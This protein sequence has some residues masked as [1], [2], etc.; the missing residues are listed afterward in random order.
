MGRL[1]HSGIAEIA[2]IGKNFTADERGSTRIK[3]SGVKA[4]SSLRFGM[5]T[6]KWD[7]LGC[8]R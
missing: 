4:D 1:A 3:K 8:F 5:T 7:R 2:V 6:L